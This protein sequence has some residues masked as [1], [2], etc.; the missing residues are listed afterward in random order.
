MKAAVVAVTIA[1]LPSLADA[2]TKSV[3]DARAASHKRW[4]PIPG[5]SG[6]GPGHT[7]KPRAAPPAPVINDPQEHLTR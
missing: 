4:S 6:I 5:T 1:L 7:K 3:L 2:S